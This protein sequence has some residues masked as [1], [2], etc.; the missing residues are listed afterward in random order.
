[1]VKGIPMYVQHRCAS[2]QWTYLYYQ[3]SCWYFFSTIK[4]KKPIAMNI[5]KK[6]L[7]AFVEVTESPKELI[8][9]PSVPTP[10]LPVRES[11]EKY[12]AHFEKLFGEANAQGPDYF[13]F[14][15]MTE[16][17]AGIPDEKARYAAAFAGLRVQGMDKEHLLGTA[18]HYLQVLEQDARD[19]DNSLTAALN[20]KVAAR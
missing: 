16:A 1:M 6:I 17:M 4:N 14:A 13:E 19:F 11:S 12:C 3:D 2:R 5:G 7:S 15:K 8:A 10:T 20:E 18:A 9:V